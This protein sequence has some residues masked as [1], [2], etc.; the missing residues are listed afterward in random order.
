MALQ[1][2]STPTPWSL[3][4]AKALIF[5]AV[6]GL[7]LA[8]AHWSDGFVCSPEDLFGLPEDTKSSAIEAV[9]VAAIFGLAA[10]A[11]KFAGGLVLF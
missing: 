2:S 9:Q 5:L 7:A 10:A 1:C 3:T 8:F 11:G 4:C 6:F